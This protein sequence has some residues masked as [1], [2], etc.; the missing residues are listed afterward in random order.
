[1]LVSFQK[2]EKLLMSVK[3]SSKTKIVLIVFLKTTRLRKIKRKALFIN[4]R[5]T[6]INTR[7]LIAVVKI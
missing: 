7:N 6:Q 2:K 1:M 5:Q 4:N 3:K